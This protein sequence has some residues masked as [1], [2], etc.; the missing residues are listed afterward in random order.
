MLKKM[1]HLSGK[2]KH[3]LFNQQL[4]VKVN[5]ILKLREVIYIYSHLVTSRVLVIKKV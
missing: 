1:A 2:T 5:G 3:G 4:P